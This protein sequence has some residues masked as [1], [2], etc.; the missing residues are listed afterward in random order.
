MLKRL[1]K[2]LLRAGGIEARRLQQPGSHLRPIGQIV[3]FL[4]DVR[5]R[6][7]EPRLIFDVGASDGAW[8]RLLEPV[9]PSARVVLVEP[10]PNMQAALTEFCRTRAHCT[11][12]PC[13]AGAT[14]GEAILTD[15]ETGSTLLP[16]AAGSAPQ[17]S[18][19][20]ETLDNIAA[21]N[22]VPE[23]VKLDVEGFELEALRGAQQLL[24]KTELFIIELALWKFAERPM[25]GDVARFM[26][27]H[28]YWVY[29]IAG[30]IRRPFDG[31]VGLV[32]V[33]F[34]R[35]GG[36]LRHSNAW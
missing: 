25:L 18:V 5:A 2:R 22:G 31:A 17:I 10:R 16:I 21:R 35:E 34:A 11:V 27:A 32:D 1:G 12:V 14:P 3:S 23:I 24:G 19:R 26:E 20:V 36:L 33:C 30:V 15:W 29:D 7:L 8:T 6:G 13:A 4:E 9:F 28:N